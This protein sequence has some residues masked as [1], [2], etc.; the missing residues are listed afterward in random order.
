MDGG[1]ATGRYYVNVR[2][3]IDL[4]TCFR[5]GLGLGWGW[6]AVR[7]VNWRSAFAVA[8]ACTSLWAF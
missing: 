2:A 3:L 8:A 6:W 4:T 5:P 1:V 7:L